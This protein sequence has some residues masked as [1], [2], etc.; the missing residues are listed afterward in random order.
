MAEIRKVCDE[1]RSNSEIISALFY[2]TV[3]FFS[4]ALFLSISSR[5]AIYRLP[6]LQIN[7]IIYRFA[8][9]ISPRNSYVN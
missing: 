9:L 7:G 6:A 8:S 1:C 3:L 5:P 4:V 2:G